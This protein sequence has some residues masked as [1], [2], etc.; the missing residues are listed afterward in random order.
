M[1]T[2]KEISPE[3]IAFIENMKKAMFK[4]ESGEKGYRATNTTHT[5]DKAAT[6]ALGMYQFVPGTH[7]EK[8]RE[9]AKTYGDLYG[10]SENDLPTMKEFRAMQSSRDDAGIEKMFDKFLSTPAFQDH[11]Y[12]NWMVN[13]IIP[14]A[15]KTYNEYGKKFDMSLEEITGLSHL[16]GVQGAKD[17]LAAIE[18]DPKLM[19]EKIS[20]QNPVS[21]GDYTKKYKQS[22]IDSGKQLT[23]PESFKD[24]EAYN[25]NLEEKFREFEKRYERIKHSGDLNDEEKEKAISN[26]YQDI[27]E[28]KVT[29]SW[30]KYLKNENN[31]ITNQ[32]SAFKN[33][34]TPGGLVHSI[35]SKSKGGTLSS[36]E[37][38]QFTLMIT[39][40]DWKNLQEKLTPEQLEDLKLERKRNG[41]KAP[42]LLLK[43]NTQK[44]LGIADQEYANLTNKNLYYDVKGLDYDK[45][46]AHILDPKKPLKREA[47][48]TKTIIYQPVDFE[49]VK[50]KTPIVIPKKEEDNNN[51]NDNNSKKTVVD[52]TKKELTDAEKKALKKKDLEAENYMARFLEPQEQIV[53]EPFVYNPDNYK[54]E[55]PFEAI[56]QGALGLIGMGQ[57]ETELP[58][59]DE[60]VSEAILQYSN[61][62]KK[63][64][65]IGLRPEEEAKMK[66]DLAGAYSEGITQIVRASGGDRNVVLGNTASI[67][68]NRIEGMSQI[69]LMDIQRKDAALEKYGEVLKY[70]ENFNTN[71]DIANHDIKYKAAQEKRIAG[72]QL[73]QAGFS[74]MLEELQYQKENGPGSANHQMQKTMQWMLTGIDSSIPDNGKGDTPHTA[75]WVRKNAADSK[76]RYEDEKQLFSQREA[77][78]NSWKSLDDI[79]R[80]R[81][82]TYADYEREYNA[83]NLTK[84]QQKAKETFAS[85][86]P[87]AQDPLVSYVG[88]K[89]TPTY[90]PEDIKNSITAFNPLNLVAEQEDVL[91]RLNSVRNG[92]NFNTI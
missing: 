21:V 61:E 24:G 86:Q 11:F 43:G 78:Y 49:K 72:A 6:Y 84:N 40:E 20:E 68:R 90:T 80:N 34:Q 60:K 23:K 67:N 71:R 70:I 85:S 37:A 57:A 59:R 30:N 1:A 74:N 15:K 39:E 2:K 79:D 56:G 27:K 92:N 33:A 36:P 66:S 69:A 14:E 12:K 63:L 17:K 25:P 3:D 44:F 64:S 32:I 18:K 45:T 41:D 48:F 16:L 29:D 53:P 10:I 47:D 19:N 35:V 46:R 8:I 28:N 83:N 65:E 82:R 58:L 50:S 62:M 5:K 55:I 26:L 13:E 42:T 7:L 51:D 9:F 75:S 31:K 4:A 22:V 77:S 81:Y 88:A 89:T 38:H 54:K 73:A 52:D 91:N 87:K 76:A